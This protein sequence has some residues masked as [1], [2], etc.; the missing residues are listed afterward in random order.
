LFNFDVEDD[1]FSAFNYRNTQPLWEADNLSKGNC[2]TLYL[3]IIEHTNIIICSGNK[4]D[5]DTH[6][7]RWDSATREWVNKL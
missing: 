4:F 2:V 7:K 5:A 1:Y 6:Q 3:I